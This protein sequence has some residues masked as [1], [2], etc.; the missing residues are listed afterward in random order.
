MRVTD[1]QLCAGVRT[2]VVQT[3][4]AREVSFVG[5]GQQPSADV[6]VA[7]AAR[8]TGR[9]VRTQ[10][11]GAHVDAAIGLFYTIYAVRLRLV[12]YYFFSTNYYHN[13]YC[14]YY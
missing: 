8:G 12:F 4:H 11:S 6:P 10:S 2:K 3:G 14:Y 5:P 7:G 1:T 9:P 13:Y